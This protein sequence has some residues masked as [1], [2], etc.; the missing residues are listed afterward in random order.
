MSI[1]LIESPTNFYNE[2]NYLYIINY[3]TEMSRYVLHIHFILTLT[4][5]IH[6]CIFESPF[7]H[8]YKSPLSIVGS[9]TSIS[10]VLPFVPC[11]G[12]INWSKFHRDH[13]RGCGSSNRVSVPIPTT[14]CSET[15]S[16]A[17]TP[18]RTRTSHAG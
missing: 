6:A 8:P 3:I 13:Y 16:T 14:D 15:S 12:V 1:L 4:L 11:S 10:Q 7:P 2:L 5:Y 9:L 18:V 17:I